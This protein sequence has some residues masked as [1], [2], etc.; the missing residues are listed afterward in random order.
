LVIRSLVVCD[1]EARPLAERAGFDAIAW[2]DF[3]LR[4]PRYS[5]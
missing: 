3:L 2:S 1:G 5:G 4:G